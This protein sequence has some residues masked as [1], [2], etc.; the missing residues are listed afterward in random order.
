M[1]GLGERDEIS[2]QVTT[3]HEWNGIK[4]LNTPVPRVLYFFLI[5]LAG[6]AVLWTVLMPSWPGIN[7]YFRGLLGADQ[8]AA[9]T[10]SVQEGRLERA[11]WTSRIEGEDFAAIQADP[12]LMNIVR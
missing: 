7:G 12:A 3:G 10:E 11:D 8:H 5:L 6:F 4:E 2:G 9:V 1:A